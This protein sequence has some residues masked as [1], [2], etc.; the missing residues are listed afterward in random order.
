M[1]D[2]NCEPKS[3]LKT[4]FLGDTPT[5]LL[6]LNRS[7]RIVGSSLTGRSHL[8]NGTCEDSSGFIHLTNA[9]CLVVADGAGSR[10]RSKEGSSTAKQA[11][12]EWA[13]NKSEVFELP[14]GMHEAF[15]VARNAIQDLADVANRAIQDYATTLTVIHIGE[16]LVSVGQ[17]GDGITV[18]RSNDGNLMSVGP[19]ER[20]EYINETTFL[21]STGWEDDFRCEQFATSSLNAIAASTDGLQYDILSRLSPQELYQPFFH[22]LFDWVSSQS[23]SDA[24]FED[25]LG[26]LRDRS[27]SDDDISLVVA[28][29]ATKIEVAANGPASE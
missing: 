20:G 21:T 13:I 5:D 7:W 3:E 11:V 1:T 6:E 22:A 23:I 19:V 18:A 24:T 12:F 29:R 10:P 26:G 25:F 28:S 17:V 8:P 15:V 14:Q 4:I 27:P 2:D 9:S 16:S